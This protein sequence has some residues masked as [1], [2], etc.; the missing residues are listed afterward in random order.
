VEEKNHAG[1]SHP[2]GYSGR[3]VPRLP[4]LAPPV[5]FLTTGLALGLPDP[6]SAQSELQTMLDPVLGRLIARGEY[7]I[8]YYP[9]ER[10]ED[11]PADFSFLQ[12]RVS[13]FAPLWQSAGDEWTGS[14]SVRHQ[15]YDTHAV[16]PDTGAPFPEELWD[17]RVGAGYRHKFENGWI[18]GVNVS[19]GSASDE[20]FASADEL[21]VR[22][23]ALLRVPHGQRNAWLLSLLYTSGEEY[24]AG[25][26]DVPIPGIAY[27]YAPSDRF[28]AIVGI[29]FSTVE[30]RPLEQ[31]TLEALYVPLR[32]VRAR[33]TYA[34]FRP[35]RLYAGFDWDSDVHFLADRADED[36]R[37]YYYEKRLTAGARFD[38]QQ[39]GVEVSGGRAYDRFYFE[40]E[41]YSD[42]RHNRIDVADGWF[43]SARV[44]VRF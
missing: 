23:V 44:N 30:Y 21:I 1:L 17:V 18:G 14:T 4:R 12:H 40:G 8:T 26:R 28:L 20:P 5:L 43:V 7:R 41:R 11:R 2:G 19:L 42:R 15:E 6:V 16:R 9:E 22:G 13:V 29:P 34:L 3:S 37:L 10:V 38:L 24:V 25:L 36:D 39:V 27:Q 32:R 35:L 31:L 33:V